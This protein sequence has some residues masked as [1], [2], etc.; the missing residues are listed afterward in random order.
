MTD[1]IE[2]TT[3]PEYRGFSR[4]YLGVFLALLDEDPNAAK[5]VAFLITGGDPARCE[6]LFKACTELCLHLEAGETLN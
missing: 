4:E 5:L 1:R 3:L 2:M 6:E